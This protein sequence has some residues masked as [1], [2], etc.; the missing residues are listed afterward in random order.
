MK[1]EAFLTPKKSGN[2][3]VEKKY[4][5]LQGGEKQKPM[6]NYAGSDLGKRTTMPH[7][8]N[9]NV[10]ERRHCDAAL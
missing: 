8:Q 4:K 1:H 10:G 9:L 6:Q 2:E 5:Q 7:S 3:K